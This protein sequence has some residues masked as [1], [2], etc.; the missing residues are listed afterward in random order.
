MLLHVCVLLYLITTDKTLALFHHQFGGNVNQDQEPAAHISLSL[1]GLFTHTNRPEPMKYQTDNTLPVGVYTKTVDVPEGRTVLL[2]LVRRE[3]GSSIS[4]NCVW[5]KKDQVLEVGEVVLLSDCNQNKATLTWTG[6]GHSTNAIQLS[7]HVQEDQRNSSDTSPHWNQYLLGWSPTGTSFTSNGQDVVTATEGGTGHRSEGMEWTTGSSTQDQGATHH[8]SAPP[9][10]SVAGTTDR[11]TLPLPEERQNNGAD[12]SGSDGSTSARARTHPSFQTFNTDATFHTSHTT[13]TET[14]SHHPLTSW[15]DHPPTAHMASTQMANSSSSSTLKTHK[16]EP[17]VSHSSEHTE[18]HETTQTHP[19]SSS[20]EVFPLASSPSQ[21][22]SSP[23][24]ETGTILIPHDGGESGTPVEKHPDSWR[25]QRSTDRRVYDPVTLDPLKSPTE[26]EQEDFNSKNTN[27]DLS[28]S[29]RGAIST[30]QSSTSADGTTVAPTFHPDISKNDSFPSAAPEIPIQNVTLHT[31]FTSEPSSTSS[32]PSYTLTTDTN[33]KETTEITQRINTSITTHTVSYSPGITDDQT[34]TSLGYDFT[35]RS[36]LTSG[37]VVQNSATTETYSPPPT[38]TPSRDISSTH[39]T[40]P[41][42][43]STDLP[44]SKTTFT[45]QTHDSYLSTALTTHTP[46]ALTSS[47]TVS[48]VVK[49]MTVP[50]PEITSPHTSPPSN[51]PPPSSASTHRQPHNYMT[52]TRG[53]L[54]SST[55]TGHNDVEAEKASE[56]WQRSNTNTPTTGLAPQQTP[57]WTPGPSVGQESTRT[58]TPS[59]L[60]SAPSWSSTKKPKFYIVPDQPAAIRVES[61]ELLLQI[62]VEESMSDITGLEED[63]AKWVE[64]YLL[65]APGFNRLL[66]VWSSG[67]AVQS[68]M[69]FKTS[70][71][72]KWLSDTGSSSSLFE[73]TGLAQAV[74][75]GRSFRS[76]RITN[77]TLGGVQGDVCGWL[78]ECPSGFKCVSHPHPHAGNYSCSSV[79]RS[80]HCHNHGICTHHPGQPPVCRCLVGEDFWYM[81][82]RCDVRMTRARLVGACLAILL[83]IVTV[84]GVLA[85]VAV[86]RYRALLIQAKVDQTRSSYRRFNHFDELSGRFWLRSWAGSA[87]SLD[88]PAFT[89]SDELLHLR[90]LDRPCCYHDDTL[91]LPSTCPSHGTRINTIYPHSSQYGWRGSE[92]SMGDGVLDSGKA[93]DLSVCSWPVEPI[94]WTPF[95]LLQQLSLHRTPTVRVTRPRSYCEGMELVDLG[96]SWTA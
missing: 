78:L 94:Q 49:F 28:L 54:P 70:E 16:H 59:A 91:S 47:N 36:T 89:R 18:K 48:T 33:R 96:K 80:D 85:F 26:S 92:M 40:F 2:Q 56:S 42:G 1:Q 27:T 11:E 7:Y 50:T 53:P 68:L 61:I 17:T 6:E 66:G 87:D 15:T 95:P 74:R 9:G 23:T 57:S 58:T 29:S 24:W 72:L 65:R 69:E 60:T 4:V 10:L 14:N 93:S 3:S 45:V 39:M 46:L 43:L 84:I 75:E 25:S 5:D 76:S 77:I 35:T 32:P 22:P 73:Q 82:Q 44:L 63:T 30:G 79:C 34:F 19:T 52:T 41:G 55:T 67:H 20:S 71:A 37:D 90:A 8:S 51:H 83:I 21:Q 88:N 81:G 62:V 13:I 38:S 86:R 64:P 12:T 31:T